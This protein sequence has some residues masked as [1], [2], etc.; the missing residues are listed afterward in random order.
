LL[1]QCVQVLAPE[2]G[3]PACRWSSARVR[4]R[5]L[6]GV[7]LAGSL[8]AQQRMPFTPVHLSPVHAGHDKRGLHRCTQ[9]RRAAAPVRVHAPRPRPCRAAALPEDGAR[10]AVLTSPDAPGVARAAPED[11][12]P[13]PGGPPERP[14]GAALRRRGAPL[15]AVRCGGPP[16]RVPVRAARRADARAAGAQAASRARCSSSSAAR[17][18]RACWRCRRSRSRSAPRPARPCSSPCGRCS[19][20]RRCSWSTSTS[21]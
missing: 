16:A 9:A 2:A 19:R 17:S 1:G 5:H 3:S 15:R 13:S 21:P 4:L 12:S 20:W 6:A 11:G 7:P 14:G 18:A 10:T 8:M